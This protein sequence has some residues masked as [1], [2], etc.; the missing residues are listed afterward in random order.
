MRIKITLFLLL[1]IA[2][3]VAGGM[4]W[5]R[6]QALK[7]QQHIA[8]TLKYATRMQAEENHQQARELFSSLLQRYPELPERDGI[9]YKLALSS[10]ETDNRAEA[11]VCMEE[12]HRNH[13]GSPHHAH[14]LAL[15]AED[16]WDEGKRDRALTFW[17]T[18]QEDYPD[19]E[20]ADDARFGLARQAYR[21]GKTTEARETLKEL[22]EAYPNSNRLWEMQRL[23]GQLNLEALYSASMEEG[24]EL[25][26]IR[27]GDTLVTISNRFNV[28]GGLI[29]RVNHIR[30]ER[31]LRVG[32]RLRIPK[33][34]FSIVVNKTD[35][36][37][38]LYN[39][40]EFFKIYQVR[41]GKDNW[42]TPVGTYHIERKVKNPTWNDPNTGKQ[43]PPNHPE[44]ELG[45]RWMAFEGSLGIHGT[46][47]EE[48]IGEYASN[49]CVGMLMPE[50]EELYDL[51]PV[52]TEVKITGKMR[53]SEP[54]I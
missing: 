46:I 49:G 51:V 27:R 20:W 45:T 6:W 18:I 54:E 17:K 42:R 33:T 10:L 3:A 4:G 19:S 43:Y 2:L 25:Y 31:N 44:N 36:T 16:A 52:G 21:L 34:N 7:K 47:R 29:A 50:V 32:K 24:D 12:I 41:T 15:L 23:L 35:N 11:L 1:L 39:D 5:V 40:G 26:T 28:S 14:A 13:P 22:V 37:L 8:K 30:D 53:K 48:T 9:L 38:T